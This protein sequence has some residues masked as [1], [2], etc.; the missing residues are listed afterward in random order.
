[1]PRK[2]GMSSFPVVPRMPGMPVMLRKPVMPGM[3]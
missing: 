3:T 2:Y 1:M